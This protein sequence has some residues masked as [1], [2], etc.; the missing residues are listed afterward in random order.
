MTADYI[1]GLVSALW[2]LKFGISTRMFVGLL[3]DFMWC[4]GGEQEKLSPAK[5]KPIWVLSHSKSPGHLGKNTGT[6]GA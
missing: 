4:E 1:V 6:P 3:R 5:E 2:Y